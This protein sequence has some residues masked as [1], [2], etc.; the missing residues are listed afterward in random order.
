MQHGALQ[1]TKKT[2]IPLRRN[3]PSQGAPPERGSEAWPRAQRPGGW[4]GQR[5]APSARTPE[6]PSPSS[7][8][9]SAPEPPPPALTAHGGPGRERGARWRR[10]GRDTSGLSPAAP[11]PFRFL[12]RAA[13]HSAAAHPAA[14][15]LQVPACT[16]RGVQPARQPTRVLI[17][18]F[19]INATNRVVEAGR[20]DRWEL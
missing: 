14:R 18:A 7:P 6:P 16:A 4:R 5:C 15:R 20:A 9:P 10:P 2:G 11:C 17:G 19:Q 8:H 1:R 13:S 12:P 3:P